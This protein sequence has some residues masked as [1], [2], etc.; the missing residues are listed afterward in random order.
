MWNGGLMI[1]FNKSFK[2]ITTLLALLVCASSLTA[3][4]PDERLIEATQRGNIE[5]IRQAL[6]D[7]AHVD[8]VDVNG[9]TPLMHAVQHN[10]FPRTSLLLQHGA[11]PD[12]Y[13]KKMGISIL[14]LAINTNNRDLVALLINYGATVPPYRALQR[15]SSDL[16]LRNL[17]TMARAK[18]YNDFWFANLERSQISKTEF[19]NGSEKFKK[20]YHTASAEFRMRTRTVPPLA[21]LCLDTMQRQQCPGVVVDACDFR[22]SDIAQPNGFLQA[23]RLTAL[24]KRILDAALAGDND[25]IEQALEAGADI[26]YPIKNRDTA[27]TMAYNLGNVNA[28]KL[29]L[30]AGANANTQDPF[31]GPLLYRC[32]IGTPRIETMLLLL[33]FKA[34]ICSETTDH[35]KRWKT[36]KNYHLEHGTYNEYL[37]S[38]RAT[39]PLFLEKQRL[40]SHIL[41]LALA[42]TTEEARELVT[43]YPELETDLAILSE[44]YRTLYKNLCHRFAY[45]APLK[46]SLQMLCLEAL[47]DRLSAQTSKPIHNETSK[48]NIAPAS[49]LEDVLPQA[50]TP[51]RKH[52]DDEDKQSVKR[53]RNDEDQEQTQ[54]PS[55]ITSSNGAPLITMH[56][57]E[58]DPADS[59]EE[60]LKA[61]RAKHKARYKKCDQ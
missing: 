50:E 52:E 45:Q 48:E 36:G 30:N 20:A 55:E 1:F 16:L 32:M 39:A 21:G 11:N 12:Y 47:Q 59:P 38:M 8:S 51:K 27:L 43:S 14:R 23:N 17:L 46:G 28:I 53:V 29:L 31:G 56:N 60:Q 25:A 10:R 22:L 61:Y 3:Q 58:N 6:A 40:V 35:L 54:A 57:V 41:S 24:A 15:E 34:T 2:H 4:T 49:S 7:G 18:H 19:E 26:N 9:Y 13:N 44:E 42:T 5:H 37:V 33:H